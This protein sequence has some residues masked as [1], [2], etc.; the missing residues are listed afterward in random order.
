MQSQTLPL[1]LLASLL[2][3]LIGPIA[4]LPTFAAVTGAVDR[5]MQV[6]IALVAAA[7]ALVTF[8]LAVFVGAGAM[9]G[10]GTSPAALILAAG[11]ILLL[12]ALRN[13]FAS[14]QGRASRPTE[15]Q[16]AALGFAPLAL[17]GIVTP[18]GVAIIII[19]ASYFPSLVDRLAILAVI[20][21]I[22]A[23]NLGAMLV[24]HAFMRHIG[25]APL[26]VLGAVFGVLQA[27]M[28]I[29]MLLSG[30]ARSPLGAG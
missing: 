9:A 25:P 14:G 4:L 27:A 17:P 19:F 23:A 26:Q 29:E 30:L 20:A 6:R 7:T 5:A 10:A 11:L 28:G 15:A 3:T 24:S 2:F 1:G 8:A 22:V 12:T 18:A 21:V 16:G 13:I